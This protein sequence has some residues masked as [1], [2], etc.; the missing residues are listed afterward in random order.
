MATPSYLPQDRLRALE[1]GESLPDRTRGAALFADISGFTPLTEAL[2]RTLGPRRGVEELTRRINAVYDAL[3]AEI[4]RFDGSVIDFAGDAITCWF[5]AD[6]GRRAAAAALALQA[7]MTA[8]PH[9]GLKVAVTSGPA[10]RLVAGDPDIQL[11]DTLAGATIARLATAEHLAA[12]GEVL[13]DTATAEAL[14]G[15]VTFGQCRAAESGERFTVAQ[16]I[17]ASPPPA[18]PGTRIPPG[19]DVLRP[20]LLP[21]VFAREQSGHGAFLVELRPVVALFLRFAGID[22]DADDRAGEKLDALVRRAQHI[23]TGH[24]GALLQLTI[25]DK[26]SYLY[27][28]FGA[29]V[30]HEDDAQRAVLAALALRAAA[31]ELGFLA[32]VQMGISQ[33]TMR[34]GACGSAT[35]CT[36]GVLGDETN[37]A[38]RL[39]TTAEP[40]EILVSGRVQQAVADLF[41]F[42]PRAL[43]SLK[44]KSEPLPACTVAGRRRRRAVRLEEPR[45]TLP[46]MG[47]QAELTLVGEKLELAARGLGQVV[48]ITAEAGMGKSRLVAEVIRLARTRGFTCYGG[49]CE[50]SG[51]STPY[52]VWRPV[53]QAFFDLDPAAPPPHQVRSL[54]D[55]VKDR[56]PTRVPAIPVLSP[57]LDLPMDDNDFSRALEP[58][59]RRNVLTAVLEDCLR[60]AAAE[61]P[62]LV[63]LEDLHWLDAL[64]HDLLETLARVSAELRVCFVLAYRPPETARLDWARARP[65]FGND[66]R[67][68]SQASRVETLPHFTCVTLDRL[69]PA[70]AEGLIRAK[71]GQLFPARAG[72]LPQALVGAL[73]AR[74]EGNP[75]YLE[76]LLNFLHDRGIDPYEERA[77][78]E[79]ELP[80]SL[81]ALILSRMDRLSEPQKVALKIASIIGR[82]FRVDWLHGYYPALG[83][84][85]RL[86]ADL[87]ELAEVDLTPLDTPEPELAYLFKHSVT[88]EVAYE[89]QSYA[90]RARLHEQLARFI[91]TLGVQRHLDLLAFHYG[92]S[93]NTAKQREYL[94][95]AGEAARAAFANEAALDYFTRLLALLDD[96]R[97]RLDLHLKRGEVSELLGQW[98]EAEADYRAALDAGE[99]LAGT[100]A[101]DAAAVARC[102]RAMGTLLRL[103]GDYPAARAWLAQARDGFAA[104]GDRAGLGLA[105]IETGSVCWRLGEYDDA[106][107]ELET[108]LGLARALADQPA[109]AQALND[110][111]N[112]AYHQG[113]LAAARRLFEESLALRRE[114]DD[115]RGTAN[116]L[117][118]LAMVADEQGD[119]AAA[120]ALFDESM[121]LFQE[122]GDKRGLSLSLNNLGIVAH[123][124]GD[125]AAAL[126]LYDRSL[127][128]H[129]EMGDRQGTAMSLINLGNLAIEQGDPIAARAAY[130]ATLRLLQEL[131]DKA[132][133]VFSLSGLAA[134]AARLA[135]APR[136]AR[137]AAAAETLRSRVGMPWEATEGRIYER[138]VATARACLGEDGFNAAW[139]EGAHMTLDAAVDYALAA[140]LAEDIAADE[141]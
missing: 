63:V 114:M 56:A 40:G 123:E 11:L 42:G 18:V 50:A 51:T 82:V 61:G 37:V 46:M 25:G 116:A 88:W 54:E 79:I 122:I 101:A 27:A 141:H 112:L 85:D 109:A 121:A 110:L 2:T 23:V 117:G 24:E 102:R 69:A 66:S 87:A 34:A 52:L 6:G 118:N 70:E 20:W 15:I 39:M 111:G 128:L 48:G 30:A 132:G 7:A 96:S 83:A 9:L 43:L 103:R 14:A 22:Y 81:H 94:R 135:D 71:L 126:A 65:P 127:A 106:R 3:I 97:T 4:E 98:P 57:L 134:V 32:P 93:D 75:F 90:A 1:R 53:W 35:R 58:Q 17:I 129:R 21:P 13:L 28:A 49:A 91:E 41:D 89:S 77:L 60:S 8:F 26:G 131:G 73:T 16:R 113:D 64:S 72:A 31:A 12:R 136:A 38:A 68:L 84:P 120:R 119:L 138:A 107:R 67:A 36:Y 100:V 19:A 124:Q 74:A 108:G 33:G 55:K 99:R 133:L 45:Y 92:R 140:R 86:K 29:P 80:A 10:R 62:I 5:D 130:W 104:L 47:R 76:E 137:L 95:A 139:S 125:Y 105:L 59:D 115:K 78:R 44:G